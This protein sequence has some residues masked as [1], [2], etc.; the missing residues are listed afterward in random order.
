MNIKASKDGKVIVV[1]NADEKIGIFI[2]PMGVAITDGQDNSKEPEIIEEVT[3]EWMVNEFGEAGKAYIKAGFDQAEEEIRR[4]AQAMAQAMIVMDDGTV[5]VD[6]ELA[7]PEPLIIG[8]MNN[9]IDYGFRNRL[10]CQ[11]ALEFEGDNFEALDEVLQERIWRVCVKTPNDTLNNELRTFLREL[12][13]LDIEDPI[14][15]L[16]E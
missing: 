14:A 10:M 9:D 6:D 4:Q 2:T 7:N 15:Y 12:Y 1:E 5:I 3:E 13:D 8:T 16:T 11:F